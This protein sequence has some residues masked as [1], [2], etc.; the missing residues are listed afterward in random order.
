MRFVGSKGLAWFGLAALATSLGCTSGWDAGDQVAIHSL[1][2]IERV[3]WRWPED[4]D[5]SEPLAVWVFFHDKGIPA[6]RLDRAL[7]DRRAG[8]TE[9]ALERR[10]LRG[11]G[12]LV[13]DLDLDVSAD[14]IAGV[15]ATGAELRVASRWLNA[16][17]FAADLSQV[18]SIEALPFVTHTRLVGVSVRGRE[19]RLPDGWQ[20]PVPAQAWDVG[21]AE[22]QLELLGVLEAHECWVTGSG[23]VIGVQDTGFTLAHEALDHVD[24]VDEYDFVNDD[25]ITSDEV[26]D[27]DG[28]HNHGTS[29]LS[30]LVGHEEGDF[31]GVVPDAAVILTKTEDLLSETRAEEDYFVA[32]L[33]WIEARGADVFSTSLGYISFDDGSG[34]TPNQ[35]NGQVAPTSVAVAQATSMGLVTV[36]ASGNT[37]PDPMSLAPPGDAIGAIAVGAVGWDGTVSD[38]SARGPTADNRTKPDLVGP[39]E[40]V[41]AASALDKDAYGPDDGTS[42]AAPL[43]AGIAAMG[44]QANPSM[45]PSTLRTLMMTSASNAGAENNDIGA[46]IPS[47]VEV[48]GT[49]CPCS[50]GDGDGHADISCGGDDCN[51]LVDSVHPGA[52]ETCDGY[53]SDCDGETPA[54]ELDLDG[55]GHLACG[56]DCDDGDPDVYLGADEIAYDGI[57]Q[58]CSGADL[59]DQDGDGFDG[60]P[61]GDD[62]DDLHDSAF[63]GGEEDCG[64]TLDNDCDGAIDGADEE[65]PGTGSWSPDGNDGNWGCYCDL[66]DGSPSGAPALALLTG[67]ALLVW[68]RRRD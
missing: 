58:D 52:A 9:R 64:D 34:Y 16:A 18:E 39:G 50:D 28:H 15:E 55:D 48:I 57:D 44:L 32:G 1:E 11:D 26:G 63:P 45:N 61:N 13:R 56:D 35:T 20:D 6:G 14:Y 24:V 5:E 67:F 25:P 49:Y 42:F 29:V 65:C 37:G 68:L 4:F 31:R 47:A 10:A 3:D 38:F 7:A 21:V 60:G 30:L 22:Q 54:D 53:D 12:P 33:E 40:M 41:W 62:C 27:W 8:L 46:G 17:S 43:V 59:T 2:Q 51:D 19:R 66:D 23:V 36:V